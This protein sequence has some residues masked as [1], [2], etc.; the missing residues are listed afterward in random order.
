MKP[1]FFATIATLILLGTSMGCTTMNKELPPQPLVAHVEIPRFMGTWYVIASIPTPFETN[2]FNATET[3]S[4]N[5]EN[6]RIDIDYRHLKNSFD[7]SEKKIPQKAFIYNK[8]TNSEWRVQPIWPLKLAY[9]IVDLAP[10]YSDTM[11]GVPNR[12][13]VWIMARQPKMD[14]P[15]YMELVSKA[16]SLGYDTSQLVRVPQEPISESAHDNEHKPRVH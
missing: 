5:T 12:G 2:A 13:H 15:R 7:G 14:E 8:E 1:F 4:W 10:D 11:I 6:D 3:Y 16:K 9:L